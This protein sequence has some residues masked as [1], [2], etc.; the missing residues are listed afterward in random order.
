VTRLL[1]SYAVWAPLAHRVRV[2]ADGHVHPMSAEGDGWWR[3]D[4]IDAPADSDY[5]FLLDDDADPLPDPRSRWQPHGVHALSRGFDPSRFA[6]TDS[7]WTGRQ[8]AG[9]MI[10]ELHLG[11]FTP[12]GTLDTAVDK[13]DHLVELGVHFVELL[14]VNGFGGTHNWGYDGVLWYAVDDSY[15]GPDAY[16]RFVDACHGRGL[17]VIQDVVYN[18]LGP[19][20][21]HLPRLGPYLHAER[22]SKWGPSINLDAVE[23]RRFIL[24]NAAMWMRDYH[25]DGLRLDAAQALIDTSPVHILQELAEETDALSAFLGRPLTLIAESDLNDPT[26]I[27][28]REAGGYGLH[29]QWSD[30]FHHSLH[31][32]LTGETTGYYADFEHLEALAKV[33]TKGFYHDG[34][35]STYR[36]REHG[37][38]IETEHVPTWRLVVA[39]QNH[40]QVGNRAVG[41][42]LSAVLDSGQL[43]IA[44]VLTMTGP[45]TP[46][47]FMGEEWGATTPWQFFTSHPDP[48]VA[49]ATSEGRIEEFARMGW[50]PSEVPD[51]QAPSTFER[52]KLDWSEPLGGEHAK[53]L[54]L[55]RSL[56]RLRR[57]HPD[58]TDPRFASIGCEYDE[59]AR[60]FV[61]RRGATVIAVNLAAA[62]VTLRCA[63]TLLLATDD[64]VT[65]AG[66]AVTLPG[67]SAAIIVP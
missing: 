18:H 48:E 26:L 56:A 67:H 57:E 60:W 20:G 55:Y 21:D 30:D 35:Y 10:Y 47:L 13:L 59:D 23:V 39:D 65:V 7:R 36:G 24:D 38:P 50:D 45:F 3:V 42:R 58:L 53:L 25:V 52:S 22:T 19:G 5:G 15:G 31:V 63:G 32:A 1:R 49:R 41:D 28:P 6:W 16:L 43:A 12:G 9:G 44:A 46:M 27:M 64:A 61:L 11:T 4:G 37:R 54:S 34:T 8:L 33:L 2:V 66:D 29:A 14:P 40:D 62:P 51:P 17:A